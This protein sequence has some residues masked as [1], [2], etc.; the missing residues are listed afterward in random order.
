MTI[1][2]ENARRMKGNKMGHEQTE[3]PIDHLPNM[4]DTATWTYR[5]NPMWTPSIGGCLDP[6]SALKGLVEI[7]EGLPVFD[8]DDPD[9]YAALWHAK[10]AIRAWEQSE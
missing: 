1:G 5:K 2:G 10:E 7:A 6:L 9:A 8:V 4:V 3:R